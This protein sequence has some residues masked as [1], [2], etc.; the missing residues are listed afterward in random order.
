MSVKLL[1]F[2]WYN[3]KRGAFQPIPKE[4]WFVVLIQLHSITPSILPTSSNEFV[5]DMATEGTEQMD[6]ASRYAAITFV[7]TFKRIV[8]KNTLDNLEDT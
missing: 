3:N 2:P 6:V 5:D 1:P 8:C 7:S 4:N